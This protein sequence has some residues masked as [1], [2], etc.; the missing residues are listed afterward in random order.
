TPRA[1]RP[2]ADVRRTDRMMRSA[3]DVRR[4]PISAE[5]IPSTFLTKPSPIAR[6]LH[7]QARR[8]EELPFQLSSEEICSPFEF[9]RS[10]RSSRQSSLESLALW[11]SL[12]WI[13]PYL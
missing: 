11:I 4:R 1:F 10:T 3:L 12:H 8:W 5:L 13:L 2:G 6:P 7:L 9:L